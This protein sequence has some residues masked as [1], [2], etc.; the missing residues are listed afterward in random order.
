MIVENGGPS[1]CPCVAVDVMIAGVFVP[2]AEKVGKTIS[3]VGAVN[4]EVRALHANVRTTKR[5]INQYFFI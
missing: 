5:H 3:G 2:P 1:L 4:G